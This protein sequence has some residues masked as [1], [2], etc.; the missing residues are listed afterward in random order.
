MNIGLQTFTVRREQKRSVTAAYERAHALGLSGFEVAR[1]D[2]NEKNAAEIKAFT[3]RSGAEIYSLQV[4]PKHV[5]GERERIVDFAR[6]VGC[7]RV[8]ISM[9]PFDCILGGEDRF[10]S[11]VSRLDREF[12]LY[13]EQGITLGYHHHNWE[14]VKLSS[15][16]TRMDEI[17]SRTEKIKIVHDTFW[18]A[19]CGID[20]AREVERFRGRLL[21]VHLRDLLPYKKG[22]SVPVRDCALGEGTLDFSRIILAALSAGAEYLVIE[23]NTKTPYRELEKSYSYIKHITEAKSNG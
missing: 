4:K 14:Y 7:H 1:L 18:T 21:G 5:F 15:G 23:Q 2:F 10:Y 22:L 19:R 12:D 6:A 13:A 11:F 8:V 3:E 20:P 17:L 9:L 16:R